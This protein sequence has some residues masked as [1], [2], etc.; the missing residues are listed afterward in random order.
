VVTLLGGRL[1]TLGKYT[2]GTSKKNR[3]KDVEERCHRLDRHRTPADMLFA[4]VAVLY[5]NYL[6][7][8]S[9]RKSAS[10]HLERFMAHVG[11]W[12]RWLAC[13]RVAVAPA[14]SGS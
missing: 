6:Q 2:P 12:V 14:A 8:P 4:G 7:N 11:L 1:K 10:E 5:L 3:P 13:G 9:T